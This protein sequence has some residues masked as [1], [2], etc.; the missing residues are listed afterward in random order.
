MKRRELLAIAGLAGLSGCLGYD[1]VDAGAVTDRKVHLAELA[2][3]VE[4]RDE[5]LA[6]R[7]ARI[8]ALEAR[9]ERL[10]ERERA[11]RVNE[12]GLVDGWTALG[13]VVNRRIDAVPP[14]EQARVAINFTSPVGQVP[15]SAA[16][17]PAVGIVVEALTLD[18]FRID[19]VG[20]RVAL[21]PDRDRTLHETV[22]RLDVNR[23]PSGTYAAVVRLTDL[24]T[25]IT[26]PSESIVMPV[27]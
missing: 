14:G 2:A 25:G 16:S 19:R 15:D 1:V 9:L 10:R 8:A 5:Q 11:P 3:T 12:A 18:G 4:R 27:Q 20:R 22:V 17:T 24:V 26:A 23:V 6:A 13:D 21:P 7:E